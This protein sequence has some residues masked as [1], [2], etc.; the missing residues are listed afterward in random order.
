MLNCPNRLARSVDFLQLISHER[1]VNGDVLNLVAVLILRLKNF[2]LFL[3]RWLLK[4]TMLSI[5]VILAMV[6]MFGWQVF[7]RLTEMCRLMSYNFFFFP[8]IVVL[9]L[10]SIEQFMFQLIVFVFSLNTTIV[11]ILEN[12]QKRAPKYKD[13]NRKKK[14]RTK[15]KEILC[16]KC[17]VCNFYIDVYFWINKQLQEHI[18]N[19]HKNNNNFLH[20]PLHFSQDSLKCIKWIEFLIDSIS[21]QTRYMRYQIS[22][23]YQKRSKMS[24][25]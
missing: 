16:Q 6:L 1:T 4:T 13:K 3:W 7:L 10:C 5:S 24:R 22:E 15:N 11:P 2:L 18:T 14:T 25:K 17:P 12:T 21:M 20:V 8:A 9:N 23:R 19:N